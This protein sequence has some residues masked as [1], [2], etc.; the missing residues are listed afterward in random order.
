[1]DYSKATN[2]QLL[3]IVN[4]D[5]DCPT[6][7]L[8]GVAVEMIKRRLWDGVILYSAK[9]TFNNVIY[10][11]E[12]L[13]KM[14]DEELIHIGHIYIME[15]LKGFKQGKRTLKTYLIM[16]LCSM[17]GK[18]LR[19]AQADKRRS[20]IQTQEVDSLPEIVQIKIFRESTNVEKEVI[21]KIMLENAL[22]CMRENERKAILLELMG[23][24][25]NEVKV[26]LGYHPNANLLTKAHRNLRKYL[27]A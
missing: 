4:Q 9:R 26:M 24:Q 8:S 25:K 12:S 2:D 15:R 16:C 6:H 13:L 10:V 21:N 17:F 22:S 23:Y 1:M 11:L 18:L 27:E 7:L 20:N 5:K 19:D 3:I 14:D